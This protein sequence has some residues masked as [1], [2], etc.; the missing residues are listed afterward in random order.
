MDN[1]VVCDFDG[2]ITKVDCINDFLDRFADEKWLDFEQDW[3]D[4]KISTCE[5]MQ[6][7]FALI[8]DMTEQKISDFFDSVQIDEYFKPFYDLAKKNNIKV[9]IISDGFEYFVRQVLER[10]G[11]SGIE[12]YSNSLKFKNGKFEMSFPYKNESCERKAGTC[13]CNF[14]SKFKKLYKKVY[15]IGDGVSDYCPADKVDFLFAKSKLLDYSKKQ[16]IPYFEYKNFQEVINNEL[17][18]R[19]NN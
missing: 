15:Y 4:G 16:N 11:I 3:I 7:Q 9:V 14:I 8:K 6:S 13:K 5:A 18:I 12:I 19:L 17:F 1:I 2:T 10:N